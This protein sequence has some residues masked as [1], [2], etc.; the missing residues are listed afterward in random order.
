M[1]LNSLFK[2]YEAE[3][4]EAVAA[5][6]NYEWERATH[7]MQ[8]RMENYA[9]E[10]SMQLE[11]KYY[12]RLYADLMVLVDCPT[13]WDS[14]LVMLTRMIK[15]EPALKKFLGYLRLPEG[16]LEFSNK[17]DKLNEPTPDD[18]IAIKC[19]RNLLVPFEA[20]SKFLLSEKVP[21]ISAAAPALR[22][23]DEKLSNTAVFDWLLATDGMIQLI[24]VE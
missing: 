18:W 17:T 24:D 2:D 4:Q 10:L 13:R 9:A 21:T 19:L 8:A 6:H 3:K 1:R 22:H 7:A 12:N 15:L 5:A 14:T 11:E 23:I 20:A 16:R